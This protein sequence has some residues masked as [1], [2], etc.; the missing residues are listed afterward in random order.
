MV[1]SLSPDGNFES[2]EK[3][4]QELGFVWL[5]SSNLQKIRWFLHGIPYSEFQLNT[6]LFEAVQL[7]IMQ[8]SRFTS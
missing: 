8:S 4:A 7:Y 2:V 1:F 3:R 6:R 5:S